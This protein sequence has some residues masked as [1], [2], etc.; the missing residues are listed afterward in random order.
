LKNTY[1]ILGE[2]TEINIRCNGRNMVTLISTND[3]NKLLNLD[4]RWYGHIDNLSGKVYCRGNVKDKYGN[5][6]NVILHRY[7]LDIEDS[8]LVSDHV[9][10]NT[11]DNTQ[12]NLRAVTHKTNMRNRDM[13]KPVVRKRGDSYALIDGETGSVIDSGFI[14]KNIA[15]KWSA[16]YSMGF[17]PERTHFSDYDR[18]FK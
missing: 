17:Y 8:E 9:N 2:I 11:L 13:N 14:S 6:T 16:I 12:D 18:I 7:L 15:L 1:R 3:L 5:F 10:G 4:S